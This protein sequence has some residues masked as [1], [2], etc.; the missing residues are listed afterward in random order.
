MQEFQKFFIQFQDHVAPRFDVYEQAIYLYVVRQTAAI[1]KEEAVI[2]FKSARKR[3]AFG[4]GKAQSSPSE[5]T[6]YEKLRSL[7]DKG[8]IELLGAERSGTRVRLVPLERIEGLV[9]ATVESTV[10]TIEEMDFFNDESNRRLILARE[11][12]QCFYCLAALHQDNYVIEHVVSRPEGDG[13]YKNVVAAC[14]TC[15]NRKGPQSAEGYMRS[16]YRQGLLSA[17]E[18]KLRLVSLEQLKSG[19]LK[20]KIAPTD[21]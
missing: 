20:P 21:A 15:N 14:R 11:G 9:P 8:F 1:G 2:G 5:A 4:K 17:D 19:L 12:A 16:L 13:S 7:A 6:I 10:H 3:L 18:I